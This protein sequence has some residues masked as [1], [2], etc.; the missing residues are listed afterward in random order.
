MF[1][2]VLIVVSALVMTAIAFFVSII[3]LKEPIIIVPSI[4]SLGLAVMAAMLIPVETNKI[5]VSEFQSFKTDRE[6]IIYF[7]DITFRSSDAFVYNNFDQ[8]KVY[9]QTTKNIFGMDI[10]KFLGVSVP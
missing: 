3:K 9:S 6:I 7:G 5:P 8:V 4:L 10:K 1:I 2:L